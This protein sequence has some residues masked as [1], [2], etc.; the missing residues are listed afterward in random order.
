M[1]G[2]RC[3]FLASHG[4]EAERMAGRCR[5]A[6]GEVDAFPG[7]WGDPLPEALSDWQGDVI[8]SYCSRWIVP[9]WLLDRAS[10]ALNFHPAPPEYPGIGG[11]NW[12]LYEERTS[13]GVTCHHMAGKVDSGP[14][15]QVVRFPI[16]RADDAPALFRRTHQH[17][18]YLAGGVSGRLASGWKPTASA[19][20]WAG[21]PRTRRQLNAMMK[22]RGDAPPSELI[23]RVRA[24][25]FGPWTISRE[26]EESG[27]GR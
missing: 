14:I 18:E 25:E 27:S 2:L 1:T 12:A 19:E 23:K 10:I 16:R 11:L 8:L 9:Q 17:L 13:F 20:S 24:F 15:V 7:D 21:P 5:Q 22:L 3:L 6:F 4:D 26:E